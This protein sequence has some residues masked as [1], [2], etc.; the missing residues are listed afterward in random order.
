MKN[1]EKFIKNHKRVEKKANNYLIKIVEYCYNL[2]Y[3]LSILLLKCQ[4]EN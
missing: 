3:Q 1:Y 4:I 2:N